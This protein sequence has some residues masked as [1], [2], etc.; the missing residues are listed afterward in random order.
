M[1][2]RL[3]RLATLTAVA[4]LLVVGTVG[5]APAAAGTLTLAPAPRLDAEARHVRCAALWEKAVAE[6]TVAN[7]KAVGLCEIDRR[8]ETLDYLGAVVNRVPALTDDHEAALERILANTR[9]GLRALR[10]KIEADT[11]VA[12]LRVDVPKIATDFR[13]YLLVSRQVHLVIAADA[14]EATVRRF[15][16]AID[17]LEAAIDRAEAAGKDVTQAREL[18]AMLI[19]DVR[20]ADAAVDGVAAEVLVLTPADWNDGTAQPVLRAARHDVAEARDHL[21]QAV[22]AARAIIA[23]LR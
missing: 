17:R 7:W 11:T 9:A 19:E 3:R 12:E 20:A 14:V 23:E 15:G 5:S 4:V 21:R 13:V 6:P 22:R 16:P 1:T 18:L 10:A 8:F 2:H